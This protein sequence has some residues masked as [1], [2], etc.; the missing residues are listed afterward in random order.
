MAWAAVWVE[1]SYVSMTS[2]SGV[3]DY[4]VT[5]PDKTYFALAA[6][7]DSGG[8]H[9]VTM[10]AELL[11][12]CSLGGGISQLHRSTYAPR[13]ETQ[14]GSVGDTVSDGVYTAHGIRFGSLRCPSGTLTSAYLIWSVSGEDFHGNTDAHGWAELSYVP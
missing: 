2:G 9:S 1:S 12:Y 5:D 8:A 14:S 11:V 3:L 10:G 4:T 13:T 6:L 7:V